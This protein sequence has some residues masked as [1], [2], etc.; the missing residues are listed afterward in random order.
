MQRHN[1]NA[2]SRENNRR[3]RHSPRAFWLPLTLG[4][5]W[6]VTKNTNL[7]NCGER[8]SQMSIFFW[9][10]LQQSVFVCVWMTRSKFTSINLSLKKQN[11]TVCQTY[12]WNTLK[13]CWSPLNHWNWTRKLSKQIFLSSDSSYLFIQFEQNYPKKKGFV[14]LTKWNERQFKII[15]LNQDVLLEV[16][17]VNNCSTVRDDRRAWTEAIRSQ[18]N[19][20]YQEWNWAQ[21]K[22]VAIVA[23]FSFM[24]LR[25]SFGKRAAS[26]RLHECI[27]HA[28]SHN[29]THTP[30][31]LTIS[32][33]NWYNSGIA[34]S[35]AIRS[36]RCLLFRVR[37]SFQ[38]VRFFLFY[39]TGPLG[40][41]APTTPMVETE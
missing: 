23:H 28:R 38:F 36:F 3:Q 14:Y 8:K 11:E 35:Y 13:I 21:Q 30:R 1:R 37:L 12:T 15:I 10:V 26:D 33:F 39:G 19:Y 34:H 16:W 22:V 2:E 27:H 40:R 7:W 5:I 18:H 31:T 9:N 24:L 4:A 25:S 41:Y 32:R 6:V 29:H 20:I 17:R